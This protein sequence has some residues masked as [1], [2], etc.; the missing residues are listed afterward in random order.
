M[1]RLQKK[2]IK[3][4]APKLKEEL[5]YK[6]IM[7]VPR[8][9]KVKI[10]V[11]L[12]KS[13]TDPKFNEIAENTLSKISGQKPVYNKAKKS[14]SVFKIR[15]GMN[16]GMSVTLRSER[17][18]DFLDKLINVTLPRVRDFRGLSPK[19]VDQRGNL[20]IGFKEHMVFPEI[21]TDEVEKLHGLEVSIATT[22]Q[23]K[24]SGLKLFRQLGFP[25]TK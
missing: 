10:N 5:G 19:S 22:A 20:T 2:Y 24:K 25:F 23:D 3:E 17:M 12:G 6:N 18:Y 14:I 11:G 15:E 13:L 9:Y 16:V 7:A 4:V 21:N 8:I 1:N